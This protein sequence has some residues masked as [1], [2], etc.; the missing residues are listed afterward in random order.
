MNIDAR[1]NRTCDYHYLYIQIGC[2]IF[3]PDMYQY[4]QHTV[5]HRWYKY[6]LMPQRL[7][8][9]SYPNSMVINVFFWQPNERRRTNIMDENMAWDYFFM[10]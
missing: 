1:A 10:F 3:K 5:E 6:S 9:K 4:K 8:L 2:V 7:L